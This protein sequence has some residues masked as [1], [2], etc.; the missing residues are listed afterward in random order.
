MTDNQFQGLILQHMQDQDARQ[1][2]LLQKLSTP[3]PSPSVSSS[4]KFGAIAGVVLSSVAVLGVAY[5]LTARFFP[6]T[7]EVKAMHHSMETAQRE[8]NQA[9]LERIQTHEALDGHP[10]IVERVKN[11][12]DV[13]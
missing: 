12:S 11:L 4:K 2:E 8:V 6:T 3:R 5:S 9:L 1:A 10:V 7:E 13:D